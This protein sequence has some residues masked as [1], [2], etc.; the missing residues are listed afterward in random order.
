MPDDDKGESD[1]TPIPCGLYSQYEVA[2]LHRDTLRLHW[3]DAAG[4]DH[5]DR[6]LPTDLQIRD[7]G[8]YL[9]GEDANG[10]ALA[11]RLDR[12]ISHEQ[13]QP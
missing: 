1:Y 4:M 13:E 6:V 10:T 9:L 12:I 2:I 7:H 11:I 8:E 3:R 5:I